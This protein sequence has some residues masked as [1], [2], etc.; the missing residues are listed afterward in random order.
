[1]AALARCSCPQ[2]GPGFIPFSAESADGL[3]DHSQFTQEFRLQSN[4]WG[5]FDWQAGL[6]YFNEDFTVDS[7]NYDTLFSDG[8]QN[9]YATQ[10]Q[11]NIAWAVYGSGDYELTPSP[12]ASRRSALHGRREGLR[13][14]TASRRRPF[15]PT[16]IGQLSTD[17]GDSDT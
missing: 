9:G 2:S 14:Q 12:E 10:Q 11:E 8:V 7:F 1:M 4:E 15:S 3:P 17:T 6:Y 5:R 13:R 16:F